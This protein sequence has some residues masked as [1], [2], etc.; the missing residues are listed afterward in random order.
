MRFSWI[1]LAALLAGCAPRPPAAPGAHPNPI[2]VRQF[3]FSPGVVTLD[4]SLG[5]SLYRGSP[6][7]PPG[8]RAATVGRAAAFSLADSIAER[9]RGLGYDA[10][11][12]DDAAAEPSGRA[13]IV[14][15]AF[16]RIFEGHRHQGAGVAAQVEVDSQV[17]GSTPQRLTAFDLDSRLVPPPPVTAGEARRAGVNLAADRL[18]ATIARYVAD[19][20]RQNRWPAAR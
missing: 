19:L 18:A 5:F 8:E 11:N 4:P 1:L 20:A 16:R 17:G 13:L 2:I 15:G 9:L 12:S 14:T 10:I 7:A 3:A 6:G